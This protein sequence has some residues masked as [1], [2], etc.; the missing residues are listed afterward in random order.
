MKTLCKENIKVIKEIEK[1]NKKI[2][3]E[4]IS[5]DDELFS[6]EGTQLLGNIY[7]SFTLFM[8]IR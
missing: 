2:A 6:E 5:N 8:L 4:T 1:K 7:G 3:K